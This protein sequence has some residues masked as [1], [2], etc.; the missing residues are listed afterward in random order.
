[1]KCVHEARATLCHVVVSEGP[2]SN[3]E[4]WHPAFHSGGWEGREQAGNV[5]LQVG[6]AVC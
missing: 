4:S 5:R 3:G 1:M 6:E 2:P